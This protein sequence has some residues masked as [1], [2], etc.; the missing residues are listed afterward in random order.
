[1]NKKIKKI[2]LIIISAVVLFLL[3][4]AAGLHIL[5]SPERIRVALETA[6]SNLLQGEVSIQDASLR[7]G[8]LLLTEVEADLED[9]RSIRA[10]RVVMGFELLPLLRRRMIF[11]SILIDRPEAEVGA[12]F[13]AG[14]I[15]F[16]P[17]GQSGSL[18]GIE[19]HGFR[20]GTYRITEGSV[21]LV[22]EEEDPDYALRRINLTAEGETLFE[23]MRVDL[24]FELT[25]RGIPCSVIMGGRLDFLRDRF[26]VDDMRI[27][28]GGGLL[29]LSGRINSVFEEMDFDINYRLEEPP[30]EMLPEELQVSGSPVLRGE[31]RNTLPKLYVSWLLDL[32]GSRF[33]YP[34]YIDK[35]QE[36]SLKFRGGVTRA[37]GGLSLNWYVI[38]FNGSSFSGTGRLSSEGELEADVIGDSV[39][40]K[41]FVS[42][43][44]PWKRYIDSGTADIRARVAGDKRAPVLEGVVTAED[45]ALSGFKGLENFIERLTGSAASPVHMGNVKADLRLSGESLRI[46]WLEAEGGDMEGTLSGRYGFD[47]KLDFTIRPEL[48]DRSITLAVYGSTENVRM[49][50]Q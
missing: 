24:D 37:E 32:T 15:G 22:P 14:A 12:D 31:V 42:P 34:P 44:P 11:N 2:S 13:A 10:D 7:P 29:T 30:L 43:I 48:Y 46:S 20:I 47:G 23:P 36:E 28:G 3:A 21:T 18:P 26:T 41:K 6:G 35:S 38:E 8:S 17:E 5:F 39:E 25:A 9:G 16:L 27:S 33:A 49:R 19:G 4:G 45:L 1:M 40:L 50:L